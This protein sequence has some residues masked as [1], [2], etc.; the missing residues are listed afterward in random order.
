MIIS[1]TP[2]RISFFAVGTYYP[3]WFNQ[4]GGQVISTSIDKYIY[5]TCRHFPR[6]FKDNIRLVYSKIEDV[7]NINQITHPFTRETLK[8]VANISFRRKIELN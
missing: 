7:N 8:F 3:K 1:K 4:H 2:Y 5:V 6:F